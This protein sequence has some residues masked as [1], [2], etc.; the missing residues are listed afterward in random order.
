MRVI[1]HWIAWILS[2]KLLDLKQELLQGSPV[3]CDMQGDRLDDPSG[4][5]YKSETV[6]L[7]PWTEL[8]ATSEGGHEGGTVWR[9]DL[10]LNYAVVSPKSRL[11]RLWACARLRSGR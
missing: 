1:N 9:E 11:F 10:S 5:F 6:L 2:Q 8:S 4:L 3:A 7:A